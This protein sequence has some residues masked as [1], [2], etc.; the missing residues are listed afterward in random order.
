MELLEKN[1]SE[2]CCM[3]VIWRQMS[4]AVDCSKRER[5]GGKDILSFMWTSLDACQSHHTS[6][7]RNLYLPYISC[8]KGT[9]SIAFRRLE[10]FQPHN[11]RTS[12]R[13]RSGRRPRVSIC[14]DDLQVRESDRYEGTYE[15]ARC[16]FVFSNE[17]IRV[18]IG[19]K[20][21]AHYL[22]QLVNQSVP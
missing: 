12:C 7:E 9:G 14:S 8:D 19:S 13:T 3:H 5:S 20:C 1:V 17:S 21:V 6:A 15:G 4:G 11:I 18:S 16:P 22:A 2:F 10:G